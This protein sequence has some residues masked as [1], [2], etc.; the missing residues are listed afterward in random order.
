MKMNWMMKKTMMTILSLFVQFVTMV[1]SFC[2][3]FPY[4]IL[5]LEFDFLWI[6][7]A[8][9]VFHLLSDLLE[10]GS[11]VCLYVGA[12]LHRAFIFSRRSTTFS[13]SNNRFV[14]LDSSV[15]SVFIFRLPFLVCKNI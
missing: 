8:E 2:G 3:M 15:P 7:F 14:N 11:I 9:Y 5:I 4:W 1:A 10:Y 13:V 6:C 12:F